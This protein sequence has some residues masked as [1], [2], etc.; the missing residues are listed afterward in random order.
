MFGNIK[1]NA[2][3]KLLSLTVL[4]ALVAAVFSIPVGAAANAEADKTV[5]S[6]ST[7]THNGYFYTFWE[8]A[9]GGSMTLGAGGNYSVT[10][11]SA[12]QNIVVG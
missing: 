4:V 6:N 8:Q 7:G 1:K 10:W 9:S 12:A 2:L 3:L 11:N 5:T